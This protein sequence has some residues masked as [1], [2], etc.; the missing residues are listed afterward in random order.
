LEERI[1]RLERE[2]E[3]LRRALSEVEKL[4]AHLGF[5]RAVE[6]AASTSVKGKS[7]A[8]LGTLRYD[9][10]E[11]IFEPR[12]DVEFQASSPPFRVFLLERVLKE[13][14][15]RDEERAS[16]GEIPPEE[17]LSYEVETKGDRIVRLVVRNY[18][19]ERRLREI[20]SS[21]RWAFDRMY[22]RI[23]VRG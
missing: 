9:E 1:R 17:V 11:I 13:M 14:R 8:S 18:R 20:R 7:G 23:M 2:V 6:A 5:K 4:I 12:G 3:D 15:I 19:D 16:R 21:I 22:E 10:N